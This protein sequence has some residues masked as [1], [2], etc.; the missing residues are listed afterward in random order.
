MR[1]GAKR[2]SEREGWEGAR[3]FAHCR[4]AGRSE[5]NY[6]SRAASSDSSSVDLVE[7]PTG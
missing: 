4:G 7:K 6:D 3:E 1:S 2:E 5:E